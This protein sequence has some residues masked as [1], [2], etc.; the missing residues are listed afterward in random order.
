MLGVS[1][2]KEKMDDSLVL[3]SVHCP[4]FNY[5]GK[6]IVGMGKWRKLVSQV[7]KD[8]KENGSKYWI[9]KLT[10]PVCKEIFELD[11]L[12]NIPRVGKKTINL[13]NSVG[14][15]TVK[16]CMNVDLDLHLASIPASNGRRRQIINILRHAVTNA[17]L[18]MYYLAVS[19]MY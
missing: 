2:I 13:L 17:N 15:C 9:L 7:L 1:I 19:M 4:L 11:N 16:D 18:G 10:C 5:T 6:I 3:K 8:V 14:L 12:N